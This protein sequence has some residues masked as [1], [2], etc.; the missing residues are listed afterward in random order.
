ME[1]WEKIRDFFFIYNYK[2]KKFLLQTYPFRIYKVSKNISNKE[3]IKFSDSLPIKT[4]VQPTK[5]YLPLIIGTTKC[6]FKCKYCYAYEG[7]YGEKPMSIDKSII[8][9][10]VDYTTKK[11]KELD[12]NLAKKEIEVGVVFFGGEPILHLEG[13]KFLIE[14]MRTNISFLN[15]KSR[16]VFKPL[17]IINTNGSLLTN[18]IIDFLKENKDIIEVVVSFDGLHHDKYRLSQNNEPTSIPVITGIKA[19]KKE[20]IKFSITCC[21]PPDE[22]EDIDKN[23]KYITNL[24]GKDTEINISFIRGSISSVK[25]KTA[26]P[27]VLESKYT[28]RALEVFGDKVAELIREGY[29]VYVKR[30]INRVSEGGYLWRCPAALYEFCVYLDGSVYP[31]H[32]FVDDKFKLGKITDKEFDPIKN[33]KIIELF[34]SRDI[35]KIGCKDCIFQTLCLSSFDCPSHSYYDL[36]NFEKV[37]ERTCIAAKKIMESLLERMYLNENVDRYAMGKN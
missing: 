13:L 22:I 4:N 25:K 3:I 33:K 29:N 8:S 17:V 31:C 18:R 1:K 26:Y 19:L 20:G 28:R 14:K 11:M 35:N 23:I 2:G 21:E 30:F 7:T 16:A 12:K 32:N 10:T 27:G 37:D 5:Y 36:G 34:K 15:K 24:F 6:N 9:A